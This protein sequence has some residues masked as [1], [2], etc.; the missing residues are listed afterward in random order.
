MNK[1]SPK[2]ETLNEAWAFHEAHKAFPIK[3][4]EIN[5]DEVYSVSLDYVEYESWLKDYRDLG[6]S[7]S[8]STSKLE[9]LDAHADTPIKGFGGSAA[10]KLWQASE[11]IQD[12]V[13][14]IAKRHPYCASPSSKNWAHPAEVSA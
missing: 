12:E 6:E 4:V 7:T 8:Q 3:A 2:L 13:F 5:N 11:S 14:E 10:K 9:W 1:K